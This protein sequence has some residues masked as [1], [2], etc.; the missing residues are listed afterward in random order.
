MDTLDLLYTQK[1]LLLQ[2]ELG[3]L[4]ALLPS[5][6]R[7]LPLAHKSASGALD[8]T[9]ALLRSDPGW[10]RHLGRTRHHLCALHPTGS[11]LQPPT[12][13]AALHLLLMRT[14]HCQYAE[15]IEGVTAA[16]AHDTELAAEEQQ[17][18]HAPG[19]NAECAERPT[20]KKPGDAA[21][22]PPMAHDDP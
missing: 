1:A 10:L 8:Q 6:S 2:D 3:A 18:V 15:A 13:A 7:P 11:H 19:L 9:V 14:L 21:R 20:T 22:W 5:T 12:T 4:F 17:S 16:V